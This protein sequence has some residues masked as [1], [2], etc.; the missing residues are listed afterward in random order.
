MRSKT[1]LWRSLGSL[2]KVDAISI[3]L[4]VVLFYLLMWYLA[5]GIWTLAGPPAGREGTWRWAW[6]IPYP[7]PFTWREALG[8][9]ILVGPPLGFF[10]LWRLARRSFRRDHITGDSH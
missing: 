7:D 10:V 2:S 1:G 8:V 5:A 3:A 9:A 6:F 4:G